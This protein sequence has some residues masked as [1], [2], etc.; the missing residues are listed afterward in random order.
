MSSLVDLKF[1]F[2]STTAMQVDKHISENS[3]CVIALNGGVYQVCLLKRQ[4]LY[5]Q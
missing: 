3:C 1:E 5:I 2:C 4:I